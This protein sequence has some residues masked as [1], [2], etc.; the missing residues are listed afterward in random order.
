MKQVID[1]VLMQSI[2]FYDSAEAFYHGL[3]LGL[4]QGWEDYNIKSNR[5]SGM[6]RSDLI[7]YP[8]NVEAPA[9]IMELKQVQKKKEILPACKDAL[10]QIEDQQYDYEL[11]DDGY[12]V[13]KYGICFCGKSCMVEVGE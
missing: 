6:G 13:I 5:E 9:I 11:L 2:S 4:F 10:Q 7:F 1:H 12:E 3:M 8:E